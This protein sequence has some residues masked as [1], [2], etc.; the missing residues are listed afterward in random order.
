LRDAGGVDALVAWA[1]FKRPAKGLT[2]FFK[3]WSK[4]LPREISGP[5]AGPI[6]FADLSTDALRDEL[7]RLREARAS[8]IGGPVPAARTE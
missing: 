7:R 6:P 4:T 8:R 5:D 3:L 1:R 2:E